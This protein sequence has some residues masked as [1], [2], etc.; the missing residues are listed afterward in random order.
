MAEFVRPFGPWIMA[1]SISSELVARLNQ[2]LDSVLTDER[3]S[4][5]LDWSHHLAG[6]VH[7]EVLVP[8]ADEAE[9][10]R[11]LGEIKTKV[12]RYYE[13]LLSENCVPVPRDIGLEDLRFEGMWAVSQRAGDFNPAHMHGGD[14]SGVVYLR[15]PDGMESEWQAEDHH[16]TAG[17]IEFIDGRPNRFARSGYRVHPRVGTLLLFPAWLLHTVYPFRSAGERRSMSFNIVVSPFA[18]S[19]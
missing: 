8:F 10:D 1:D 17:I 9:R 4:A 18:G 16:P 13:H 5:Q 19:S 12:L 3:A 11:A 15:L 6:N 2:S 7:R 14:F